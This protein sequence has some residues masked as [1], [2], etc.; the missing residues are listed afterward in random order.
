QQHGAR[1]PGGL[2]PAAGLARGT[3]GAARREGRGTAVL[4]ARDREPVAYL[5][6]ERADRRRNRRFGRRGAASITRREQRLLHGIRGGGRADR[7]HQPICGLQPRRPSSAS[8]RAG[9]VQRFRWWYGRRWRIPR[10]AWRR[11][12]SWR[13]RRRVPWRTW[14]RTR[15][16]PALQSQPAARSHFLERRQFR[17]EC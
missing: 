8:R 11:W 6:R 15:E 1:P 13:R 10:R 4:G 17:A 3:A 16:F 2:Y 12:L 9:C 14:R 7:I 5:S